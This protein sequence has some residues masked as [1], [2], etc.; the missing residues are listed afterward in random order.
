MTINFFTLLWLFPIALTIH[1]LEEWQIIKWYD[2]YFTDM[3]ENKSDTSTRFFLIFISIVSFIWTG[4]AVFTQSE[5]VATLIMM[6]FMAIVLLNSFQHIYWLFQ[7]KSVSP[8]TIS[9][10]LLLLPICLY[11]ILNGFTNGFIPWWL[12]TLLIIYLLYGMNET[13]KAKNTLSKSFQI[14]NRFSNYMVDKLG[15][16]A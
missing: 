5:Q 1:E 7:F 14:I 3:P 12:L 2:K 4:V 15:I 10:C 9:A 16:S 11:I 8:G 6:P 13:I